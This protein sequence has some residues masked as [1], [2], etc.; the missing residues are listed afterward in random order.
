MLFMLSD[1]CGGSEGLLNQAITRARTCELLARDG[2]LAADEAFTVGLLS[3]LGELLGRPLDEVVRDLPLES[4]LREAIVDEAG[5]MGELLAE[6]RMYEQ[7]AMGPLGPGSESTYSSSFN[8]IARFY[9]ESM[10]WALR[11]SRDLV[12]PVD[13][14]DSL[15]AAA[16]QSQN[17]HVLR[18]V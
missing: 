16:V 14:L 17:A 3:N 6:V 13:Q 9:L 5:P 8:Q 10:G 4:G 11:I 1:I 15:T 12:E 2:G 7:L 18:S